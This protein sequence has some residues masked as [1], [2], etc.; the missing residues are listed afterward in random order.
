MGPPSPTVCARAAALL[1]LLDDRPDLAEHIAVHQL[2]ADPNAS[3]DRW[4][5]GA[6]CIDEP[7]THALRAVLGRLAPDRRRAVARFDGTVASL[8]LLL[9]EQ[10]AGQTLDFDE[11]AATAAVGALA[12]LGPEALAHVAHAWDR[13]A[14]PSRD[15]LARV[16]LRIVATDPSRDEADH[17]LA[18]V[19]TAPAE[20]ARE[21]HTVAASVDVGRARRLVLDA[22]AE[23]VTHLGEALPLLAHVDDA[24]ATDLLA[25]GLAWHPEQI[26]AV[27]LPALRK[28]L[29]RLPGVSIEA[30]PLA[31]D[32]DATLVALLAGGARLDASIDQHLAAVQLADPDLP[33]VP[34]VVGGRRI[35]LP[36]DLASDPTLA[37]L[38]AALAEMTQSREGL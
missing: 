1:P 11:P 19:S 3:V 30:P 8:H 27:H 32:P 21:L 4:L 33:M 22:F 25:E 24:L 26:S 12:L 34:S 23:P 6:S 14:G 10:L 36:L 28:L 37:P 9:P 2:N 7:S 13:A 38:R 35:L 20:T 15:L 5:S 16:A 29:A 17:L 18:I 31:T